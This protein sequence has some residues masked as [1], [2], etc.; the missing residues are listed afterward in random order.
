MLQWPLLLWFGLRSVGS[1]ILPFLILRDRVRAVQDHRCWRAR[2]K[3]SWMDVLCIVVTL[4]GPSSQF[5][6]NLDRS[7]RKEKPCLFLS[8]NTCFWGLRFKMKTWEFLLWFSRLWTQL[9]S[10]RS[11]VR[12]LALLSALRIWYCH[13]LWYR[14]QI[15]LRTHVAVAAA[16]SCSSDLTPSLGTSL[17][18]GHHPKNKIK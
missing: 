7:Q 15:W 6:E 9:V 2:R 16:G 3:Q 10:L 14:S 18:R 13:E 12:S 1:Q 5:E 17:C 4:P 11:W 8:G